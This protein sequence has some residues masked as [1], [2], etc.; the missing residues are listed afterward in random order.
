MMRTRFF[1]KTCS[2]LLSVISIFPE[3]LSLNATLFFPKI[4]DTA[5][6]SGS[7][8]QGYELLQSIPV[9]RD[10]LT[11][12]INHRKP[13]LV[14]CTHSLP[15]SIFAGMRVENPS[16]PSLAAVS[17]D[18][19]VHPYW[20]VQGV[21]G[22][23]VASQE[24]ADRLVQKGAD[25]DRIRV[26]GIPIDPDAET[27][28][29]EREQIGCEKK[30]PYKV[31][32][33]AGGKRL[34][35]YVTTWAKTIS[36]LSEL[37]KLPAGLVHWNVVCGKP[38]AFS[39]LL[40]D[41]VSERED[42]SLFEYVSDFMVFLCQQDFVIT[43][44]GGLILAE[45]MALGIPAILVNRGS[46]QEAANS[47]FILS[48][49]GGLIMDNEKDIL[50]FIQKIAEDPCMIQDMTDAA[51]AIGKPDAARRSAEWLLMDLPKT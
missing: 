36:L 34:A 14:I 40:S 19:M 26:F 44:P 31:L 41:T 48:H 3:I 35:P 18:F 30:P 7:M 16:L 25:A 17:T 32:I 2:H 8:R 43:K 28:V 13:D 21:D 11:E 46:G 4:Y 39:R 51:K 24:A 45:S 6:Q 50:E 20:P 33:L 5:W 27:A 10:R 37:S 47:E 1:A 42:V 38:S 15:C 22:F 29:C 9:L 12:L 23:V 49:G